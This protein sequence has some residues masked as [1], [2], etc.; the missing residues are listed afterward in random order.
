MKNGPLTVLSNHTP[1][2]PALPAKAAGQ[3]ASLPWRFPVLPS[4]V[5]VTHRHLDLYGIKASAREIVYFFF[6]FGLAF[7]DFTVA[8]ALAL[9]LPLAHAP[10]RHNPTMLQVE[11]VQPDESV[12]VTL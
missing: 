10:F 9:E 6:D 2:C 1:V 7:L 8:G 3:L 11:P 5:S 4:R 12:T